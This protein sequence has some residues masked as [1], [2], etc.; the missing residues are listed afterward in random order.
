MTL[1]QRP[2]GPP[3]EGRT[4]LRVER[5]MSEA[6][7]ARPIE[8]VRCRPI[9]NQSEKWAEGPERDYEAQIVP[10][11]PGSGPFVASPVGGLPILF[12]GLFLVGLLRA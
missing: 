5:K 12:V 8:T 2:G 6:F 4:A 7:H 3:N 11:T 1:D 10:Q 9:G